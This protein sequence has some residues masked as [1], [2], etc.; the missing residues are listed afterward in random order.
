MS[1]S[2]V[3]RNIELLPKRFLLSHPVET[4]E[5][6]FHLCRLDKSSGRSGLPK[7]K[8]NFNA[9]VKV[10]FLPPV[11]NSLTQ[12]L[13]ETNL[14]VEHCFFFRAFH[15]NLDSTENASQGNWT[16]QSF[17]CIAITYIC[18]YLRLLSSFY[19]RLCSNV[20]VG[21]LKFSSIAKAISPRFLPALPDYLTNTASVSGLRSDFT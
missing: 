5:K 16:I 1:I 6:S 21:V 9:K 3:C 7:C 11:T 19:P 13:A 14:R 4:C 10:P 20:Y 15:G 12:K 18:I 8:C 2:L 17:V